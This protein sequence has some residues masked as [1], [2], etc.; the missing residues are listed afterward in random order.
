MAQTHPGSVHASKLFEA[1]RTGSLDDVKSALRRNTNAKD[2]EQLVASKDK[3]GMTALHLA[4]LYNSNPEVAMFLVKNKF[5]LGIQDY[6]GTTPLL[7]AAKTGLVEIL[8]YAVEKAL[9]DGDDDDL[10]EYGDEV[11]EARKARVALGLRDLQNSGLLHYCFDGGVPTKN[12]NRK[13]STRSRHRSGSVQRRSN[14]N[15]H[16]ILQ[17]LWESDL[18]LDLDKEDDTGKTPLELALLNKDYEKSAEYLLSKRSKMVYQ[19]VLH[20]RVNFPKDENENISDYFKYVAVQAKDVNLNTALHNCATLNF[21]RVRTEVDTI[22]KESA[23]QLT[24]TN[25]GRKAFRLKCAEALLDANAD[26]NAINNTGRTPLQIAFEFRFDQMIKLLLAKGGRARAVHGDFAGILHLESCRLWSN[27][28]P[29]KCESCHENLI[30]RFNLDVNEKDTGS[31]TPLH[32]ACFSGNVGPFAPDPH[33]SMKGRICAVN[34][35]LDLNADINAQDDLGYTPLMYAVKLRHLEIVSLLVKRGA[36]T[37]IKNKVGLSAFNLAD[38]CDGQ[39]NQF[40]NILKKKSETAQIEDEFH[41]CKKAVSHVKRLLQHRCVVDDTQV[42]EDVVSSLELAEKNLE[43]I[44][45]DSKVKKMIELQRDILTRMRP[46]LCE[47]VYP[48]NMF[49]RL[50]E[51]E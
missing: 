45:N 38:G 18:D 36:I 35:L 23:D 29:D 37:G 33:F 49:S 13:G 51:N 11:S 28:E 41:E 15:K 1:A 4:C 46:V 30:Q 42:Q 2:K 40:I 47:E 25:E 6:L 3:N 8:K 5:D 12:L 16:K 9:T 21:P 34:A 20:F 39:A 24:V 43:K 26:V 17:L 27:S 50:R 48:Q 10:N 14:D 22:E 19:T 44:T 31:R 7:F 32:Y